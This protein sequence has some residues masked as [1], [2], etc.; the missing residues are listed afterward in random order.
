MIL[1]WNAAAAAGPQV[2]GGKGWNLGRMAEM[3]VPVPDGF[4]LAAEA[5]QGRRLGEPVPD[6]ILA[7]V[8]A[9]LARRKWTGVPLAVRSSAVQEDSGGASF[10]GIHASRLNVIGPQSLA[11]AIAEVWDSAQGEAAAAYRHRL[12]L[13][14]AAPAMAVVVM[15]LLPALASG[16]VFTCDPASGRDD[17]VVISAH[18]G[19]GEALVGGHADGDE[20][21]LE[22]DRDG[23]YHEIARRRGTKRR[24]S[25]PAASSTEL[26][27]TPAHMATQEVL[28][29]AQARQ[30]AELAHDA[31]AAL[32]Y[33]NPRY[34][35]EWVWDGTRFW[36]VQARPVTATGRHTYA[37]LRDQPALWSRGNTR[38]VLPEPLS[39]QDWTCSRLMVDRMLSL[40]WHLAGYK[41]LPGARRGALFH[42]RLYLEASL[43][44]WEAFDALGV[45]PKAIN[46][47]MGGNQPEIAVPP[48]TLGQ[49]LARMG[50][51]LRY[52]RRSRPIRRRAE[53]SLRRAHEQAAQWRH[54]PLPAEPAALAA[55]MREQLDYLRA[56]DDLYFLQ[57]SGGGG[58]STL[59][60]LLDRH[61]PGQGHALAAA[62][63]AG[64][65]PSV[66]ARQG[67]DLIELARIATE[68][69]PQAL[70]WLR[71]PG[72]IAGQ[73]EIALPA[74]SRFRNA[75]AAFLDR[76]GHRALAE[77]YLRSPRWRECPTYLFE[78]IA[79]LVGTDGAALRQRQADA[80]AAAWRQMRQGL[81]RWL[82]PLL[83]Q[84]VR[85]ANVECN[86]REAARG[87]LMAH[88]EVGRMR[89]LALAERMT[90]P[91]KLE[92]RDDI[93][94]LTG[95]E[96][97][98]L[99]EGRLSPGHAARRVA[100]RREQLA[101]WAEDSEPDVIALHAPAPPRSAR[102]APGGADGIWLGTAVGPGRAQGRAHV[103]AHPGDGTTMAEGAILV[104]PSTDPGWTPLFIKA[105][106]LVMET[107]GYLSH[108]AIVAREFG[109]P[110]VVNM[111][112]IL[113]QLASG[114]TLEVDGEAGRVRRLSPP[115]AG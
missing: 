9:E 86:H 93:F 61:F 84:L 46:E 13:E 26:V 66:T 83:R 87:A 57:G 32:D 82:R 4:V 39:P 55:L 96:A 100:R 101:R 105:G 43:I 7:A 44:Q 79:G 52:V 51:M 42:G 22:E 102:P 65:T 3:G 115:P 11:R 2:A 23:I 28:S 85:Q 54:R 60:R 108:G 78:V 19:L 111:P 89:L 1:D 34:D 91:G 14:D 97:V 77:T 69:D 80:S 99:A 38:E 41:V 45:P 103:A 81:P 20:Y 76:Y 63:L 92:C 95:T 98:A 8:T 25:R 59:V 15:P 90:G 33:A 6:A 71:A 75:F 47:L 62:L 107:G 109:I 30:L 18:W 58:L 31:A 5:A 17:H 68:E 113:A 72:R 21:R 70:A 67:Y 35:L 104:A 49:K 106:G 94:N 50:R 24:L 16:I 37:A 64:G 88:L 110:A 114:E 73:W 40:G 48:A 56:A 36:I 27:D 29:P 12:G 112:G 10:A 74:D 53:D